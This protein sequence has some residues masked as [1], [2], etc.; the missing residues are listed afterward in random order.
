MFSSTG[1]AAAH[2]GQ[3]R[4]LGAAG[5]AGHR[6]VDRENAMLRRQRMGLFCTLDVDGGAI[7][8]QRALFHRGDD[9]GPD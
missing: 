2:E 8:D 6:R 4:A 5:A 9:I 3:G 7:D 1:L